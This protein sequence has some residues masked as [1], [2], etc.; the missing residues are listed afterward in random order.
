M[1]HHV[2]FLL[3]RMGHYGT[4]CGSKNSPKT[5]TKDNIYQSR[6]KGLTAS[7]DGRRGLAGCNCSRTH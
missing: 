1:M 3:S 6:V 7:T 4:F 2:A 5:L